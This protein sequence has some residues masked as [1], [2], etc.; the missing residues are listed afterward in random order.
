MVPKG[1]PTPRSRALPEAAACSC[2][3][4]PMACTTDREAPRGSP[5]GCCPEGFSA[6]PSL[7]AILRLHLQVCL[8]WAQKTENAL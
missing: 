4:G 1:R 3:G 5:T 8:A 6:R 7:R 2:T